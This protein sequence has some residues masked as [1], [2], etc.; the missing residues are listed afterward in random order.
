M[1]GEARG[2]RVHVMEEE[3][4]TGIKGATGGATV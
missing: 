2:Q 1:K 4:V 3:N